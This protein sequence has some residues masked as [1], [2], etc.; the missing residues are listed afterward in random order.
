[1]RLEEHKGRN[2]SPEGRGSKEENGKER[3][4][5]GEKKGGR[6]TGERGG[7][8]ITRRVVRERE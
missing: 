8:G 5:E 2:R 3:R 4:N 7:S 1:M 6:K